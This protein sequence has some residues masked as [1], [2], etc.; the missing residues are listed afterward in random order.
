[1][2]IHLWVHAKKAKSSAHL[3]KAFFFGMVDIDNY[4]WLVPA[5]ERKLFSVIRLASDKQPRREFQFNVDRLVFA[6]FDRAA[7]A[8]Y[9]LDHGRIEI[10]AADPT[11]AHDFF[12]QFHA[13]F[14][15]YCSAYRAQPAHALPKFVSVL[16]DGDRTLTAPSL[17]ERSYLV[18]VDFVDRVQFNNDTN[19]LTIVTPAFDL[20]ICNH[21][22]ALVQ[23]LFEQ[24]CADLDR[25]ALATTTQ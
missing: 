12:Q 21:D 24:L 4:T 5:H 2:W 9:T 16:L 14:D 18:N 6:E 3:H 20:D 22:G 13:L 7:I 1:M 23:R 15:C 25:Y 17:Y 8:L 11:L 10:P 19:A